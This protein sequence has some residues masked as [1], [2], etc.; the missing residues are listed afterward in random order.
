MAEDCSKRKNLSDP[1]KPDESTTA[2]SSPVNEIDIIS[3]LPDFL[4]CHILSFLPDKTTSIVATTS[5]LSRR[6]RYVWRDLPAF[7]FETTAQ[8]FRSLR[9]ARTS[10]KFVLNGTIQEK[11]FSFVQSWIESAIV[12]PSLEELQVYFAS[13]NIRKPLIRLP[14]FRSTA[15]VTIIFR[16]NGRGFTI[17]NHSSYHLP[18][19]KTMTLHLESSNIIE[20][21]LS[22]CPV[23]ETLNLY[24]Y[25][26]WFDYKP[27]PNPNNETIRVASSS[28]K[29]LDI[30]ASYESEIIE[31][32]E[33]D[34]PSLEYLYL[35]ISGSHQLEKVSARNLQ[36]VE[37]AVLEFIGAD[38]DYSSIELLK[39]IRNACDL[40][41]NLLPMDSI[42]LPT[43]ELME[44]NHL[45]RLHLTVQNFSTKVVMDMLGKCRVLKDLTI[46]RKKGESQGW[47]E[48]AEVPN[49]LV[50]HLELVVFDY[51][52]L[53]SEDEKEFIAYILK[54]GLI[55]KS[56]TICAD[57]NPM[58][59]NVDSTDVEELSLIPPASKTCYVRFHNFS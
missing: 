7:H 47:T 31:E 16:G 41:L 54:K 22:G 2:A 43:Y 52:V 44:F 11:E 17:L 32:L 23:L 48:P 35:S 18:S 37:N 29:S 27:N 39:E 6:W 13:I 21:L 56:V 53:G 15:L 40:S 4:L 34:A 24:I 42:A 8:T 33:I 25:Q 10:R 36:K 3:T 59:F 30:N 28:L 26:L 9:T 20:A 55:L 5:L 38:V 12:G 50:S 1:K 14:I 45:L 46:V 19:L 58:G 51:M 49:C 57:P